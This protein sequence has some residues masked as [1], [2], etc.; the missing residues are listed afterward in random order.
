MAGPFSVP[1]GNRKKVS[2]EEILK[3]GS[4]PEDGSSFFLTVLKRRIQNGI[5]V[6]M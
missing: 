4:L 6:T 5:I 1:A 2:L 3:R